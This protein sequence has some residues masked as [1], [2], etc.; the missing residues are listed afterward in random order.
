MASDNKEENSPTPRRI[1]GLLSGKV[2]HDLSDIDLSRLM[3]IASPPP[4]A[5][6]PQGEGLF[7]RADL[8]RTAPADTD[9][10]SDGSKTSDK[11]RPSAEE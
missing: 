9:K 10:P 3:K 6:V 11:P 5:A 1:R 7:G 8:K 2:K 4:P